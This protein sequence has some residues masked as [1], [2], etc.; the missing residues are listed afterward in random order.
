MIFTFLVGI[1]IDAQYVTQIVL[2]D[3]LYFSCVGTDF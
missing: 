3:F 1:S 2:E